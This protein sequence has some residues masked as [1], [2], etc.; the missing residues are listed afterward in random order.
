[1]ETKDMLAFLKRLK[2]KRRTSG[3]VMSAEKRRRFRN[4]MKKIHTGDNVTSP[5]CQLRFLS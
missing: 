4:L 1:M 3:K 5:V 2:E